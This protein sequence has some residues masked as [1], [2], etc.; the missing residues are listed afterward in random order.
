MKVSTTP[1]TAGTSSK[2]SCVDF[3]HYRAS[4]TS[5]TTFA[6]DSGVRCHVMNE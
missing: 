1:T 3:C 2:N 6:F 5:N 4:L